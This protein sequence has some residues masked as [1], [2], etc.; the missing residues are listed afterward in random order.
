MIH[1]ENWAV[2]LDEWRLMIFSTIEIIFLTFSLVILK[3][4]NEK[5][6]ICK[7]LW[8]C[9]SLGKAENGFA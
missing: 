1:R 8:F 2:Y 6:S 3:L 7:E 9:K 4:W 5:E